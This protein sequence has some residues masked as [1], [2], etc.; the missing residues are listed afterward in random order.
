[1]ELM[2]KR[3]TQRKGDRAVAQAVA[4]FTRQGYDV[5]LPFTESAAYDLIV[6][7]DG[8]LKRVQVK[9]SSGKKV[10]L[11]RIHSNSRGYVVKKVRTNA[12]DWLYVLD[13][14][15]NEYLFDACFANRRAVSIQDRYQISVTL[16]RQNGR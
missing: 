13:A 11:R 14:D 3:E 2:F 7:L 6:D 1:M 10:D 9:F 16:S 15:G 12:Y 4:T 8:L 5:A